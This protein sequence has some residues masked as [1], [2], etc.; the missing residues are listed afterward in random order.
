MDDP[1][2]IA[3]EW[4]VKAVENCFPN[5]VLDSNVREGLA[6]ALKALDEE[7]E[8]LIDCEPTIGMPEAYFIGRKRGIQ[9][10]RGI[11]RGVSA[12]EGK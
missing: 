3:P 12:A 10:V 8:K 11:F 6:A 2:I 4:L 9:E 1:E 5:E 7:L